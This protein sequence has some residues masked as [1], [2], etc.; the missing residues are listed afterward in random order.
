M[1]YFYYNI[2][3]YKYT[4]I[5]Y[6]VYTDPFELYIMPREQVKV[7]RVLRSENKVSTVIFLAVYFTKKSIYFTIKN[8]ETV[9]HGKYVF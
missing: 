8:L 6:E 7:L 3:Y 1:T 4:F 9:C 2:H 5:L